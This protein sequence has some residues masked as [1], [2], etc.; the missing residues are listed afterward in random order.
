[1]RTALCLTTILVALNP[2]AT[3]G[4]VRAGSRV[5]VITDSAGVFYTGTVLQR[6]ADSLRVR[7]IGVQDPVVLPWHRITELDLWVR[8]ADA[9][10]GALIGLGFGGLVGAL[11]VGSACSRTGSGGLLHCSTAA[12]AVEGFFLVGAVG[13]VLGG[14]LGSL[15]G[16]QGWEAQS[17]ERVRIGR[18]SAGAGVQFGFSVQ[19]RAL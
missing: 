8:H 4:Q 18:G 13:A 12:G 19:F 6:S 16:T 11:A 14:V 17:L 1:M 3:S 5:R 9:G 2:T 10:R 7:A 15:T